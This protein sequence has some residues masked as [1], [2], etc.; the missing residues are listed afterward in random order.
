MSLL[1]VILFPTR[2]APARTQVGYPLEADH[3][4][5]GDR[6]LLADETC[7]WCG[8]YPLA[9]IRATWARRAAEINLLDQ[10][11]AAT[12]AVA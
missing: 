11:P 3:C 1:T 7:L 4:S 6:R 10:R 12:A 5:C 2:P 8:R 9:T